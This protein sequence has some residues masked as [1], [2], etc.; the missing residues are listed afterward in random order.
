MFFTI[1]NFF[2]LLRHRTLEQH[3]NN[4]KKQH[5]TFITMQQ[6]YITIQYKILFELVRV[7]ILI[8]LQINACTQNTNI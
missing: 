7:K 5:K 6:I 3:L 1:K 8:A 4:I 2:K